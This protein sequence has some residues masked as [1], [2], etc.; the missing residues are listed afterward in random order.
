MSV[1]VCVCVCVCL[2]VC[3]QVCVIEGGVGDGRWEGNEDKPLAHPLQLPSLTPDHL[4]P[5]QLI[6]KTALRLI[7]ETQQTLLDCEQNQNSPPQLNW[8]E[9]IG[10]LPVSPPPPPLLSN[11]ITSHPPPPPSRLRNHRQEFF[12][13]HES[14]WLVSKVTNLH[15]K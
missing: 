3:V 2:S 5:P 4:F 13:K 7:R 12:R 1:N 6:T 10:T 15:S 9:N 8:E 14:D 11:P